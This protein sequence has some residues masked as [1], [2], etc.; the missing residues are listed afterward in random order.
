MS[1]FKQLCFTNTSVNLV[2][3]NIV[4]HDI[5]LDWMNRQIE[6]ID[7]LDLNFRAILILST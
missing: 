7:N 2:K 6:Y 5:I 3:N 1:S 4:N